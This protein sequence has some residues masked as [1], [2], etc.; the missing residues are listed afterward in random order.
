MDKI[1]SRTLPVQALNERRRRAVKMRLDGVP[2]KDVAVQCELCRTIVIAA[3]KAFHAGGWR[4]VMVDR[5]GRPAGTGRTLTAEQEREVQQLIRDR[6]L[7]Q[8][9]MVYALWTRQAVAELIPGSG[10]ASTRYELKTAASCFTS[11]R[12]P[13]LRGQ[14]LSRRSECA[15]ATDVETGRGTTRNER[16]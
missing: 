16:L 2:L 8:L 5:P 7:D 6:T 14:L 10:G 4:A 13:L 12:R 9:K 11:R 1:D 3:V 15:R